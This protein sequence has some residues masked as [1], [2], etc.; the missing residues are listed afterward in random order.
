MLIGLIGMASLFL[1]GS[2]LYQEIAAEPGPSGA[3][4]DP[5]EK[6]WNFVAGEDSTNDGAF[7]D[8][9]YDDTHDEY[10]GDYEYKEP[11]LT[12]DEV[13]AIA[14]AHPDVIE[15]CENAGD[16]ESFAYYD[17]LSSWY[18]DIYPM[19]WETSGIMLLIDDAT[20]EILE[21]WMPVEATMTEEEVLAIAEADPQVIALAA[22]YD[23]VSY[24]Y[25]DDFE[26]LW[27]VGFYSELIW[28]AYAWVI[29]D[30]TTGEIIEIFVGVPEAPPTMTE[31]E[32]M[33][34]VYATAEYATI[35]GFE[36]LESYIGVYDGVWYVSFYSNVIWDVYAYFDIDDATGDILYSEC[37]VPEILP[38]LTYAEAEAYFLAND[39]VSGY[40]ATYPDAEYYIGFYDGYWFMT[41]YTIDGTEDLYASLE[42]ASMEIIVEIV[43]WEDF[44]IEEPPIEDPNW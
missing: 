33:D 38:A 22:E 31:A 4:D 6:V 2:L 39:Q 28:D 5:S 13:I 37:F 15:W 30:D 20:G 21:L 35:A 17:G 12:E 27:C 32:V 1:S 43:D 18:V 10:P 40:L 44:P 36:G 9:G 42:E 24:V 29:I 16:Y 23:L 14:M 11:T 8:T 3:T 25:F 26:A 7:Q 34:L 41:A 19:D